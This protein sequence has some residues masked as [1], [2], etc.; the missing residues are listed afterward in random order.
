MVMLPLREYQIQAASEFPT[1][2]TD[3]RMFVILGWSVSVF[4]VVLNFALSLISYG[5]RRSR[6]A[7]QKRD[8]LP[9]FPH[10]LV[11]PRCLYILRRTQ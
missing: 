3:S 5:G 4:Y 8:V 2:E 7:K 11:C 9:R 6:L 10:S 1:P